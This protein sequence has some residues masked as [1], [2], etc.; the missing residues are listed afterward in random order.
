MFLITLTLSGQTSFGFT[1]TK[2]ESNADVEQVSLA[3]P[4]VG[5]KLS[6]NFDENKPLDDNFL[7]SAK[8]LYTPVQG[9][10]YA[11]PVVGSIG[12]GSGDLLNPESGINIGLYPYYKLIKDTK[13]LLIAH[14][15]LGYKLITE[16]VEA[17]EDAPQQIKLLGGL[18]A[19]F[20]SEAGSPT[21]VSLTPVY[22]YH[23]RDLTEST[24]ALEITGIIP[25]SSGLG[26]L[27]EG[28]VPFKSEF[29]G[30]FRFG[31]VARG[32]L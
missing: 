10:D 32:K 18:E 25:V 3:N 26:I 19:V 5:A 1:H 24:G 29:D 6:Y 22:L 14:G 20:Y 21:T 12:L 31:V 4:W 13:F 15:G 11:V 28:Q 9:E 27:A 8:V 16:G 7:F 23:T 17:G 30:T 2:R